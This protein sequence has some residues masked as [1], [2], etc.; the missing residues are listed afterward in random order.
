[1]GVHPYCNNGVQLHMCFQ[2]VHGGGLHG[3]HHADEGCAL[4][5]SQLLCHLN[6]ASCELVSVM[7]IE[8]LVP[9]IYGI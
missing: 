2:Y 6:R 3:S 5:C 9:Y 4:D 1:M 7:L 8:G